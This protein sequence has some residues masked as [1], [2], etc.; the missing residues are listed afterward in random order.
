MAYISVAIGLVKHQG[1]VLICQREKGSHL[2]GF[3]EFPG[4]KC[5][6]GEPL[7]AC[8]RRELKEELGITIGPAAR[9]WQGRHAYAD[10]TVWLTAFRCRLV[11]GKPYARAASEIRWVRPEDLDQYAFP[12]ANEPLLQRIYMV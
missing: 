9:F 12:P 2:A 11:R 4:G 1:R 3:W 6:A 7:E 8:L 5:R 10:R